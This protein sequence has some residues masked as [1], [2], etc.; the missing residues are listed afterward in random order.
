MRRVW[1]DTFVEEANLTVHVSALRKAL[2]IQ[3]DGR[4][5]I[6]RCRGAAT[7]TSARRRTAWPPA[8]ARWPCCRS[9]RSTRR[10][11]TTI[12]AWGW[13]TR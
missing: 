11:P 9:C 8:R 6:E 2:G 12:S 4:P 1:P 3:P 13:P 5:W 10:P 7:A